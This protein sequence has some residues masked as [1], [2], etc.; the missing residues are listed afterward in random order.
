[1]Q[2]LSVLMFDGLDMAHMHEEIRNIQFAC[3]KWRTEQNHSFLLS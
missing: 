1:M 3:A 2:T